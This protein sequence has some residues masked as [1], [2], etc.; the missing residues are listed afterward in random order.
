[1]IT[2]VFKNN[3]QPVGLSFDSSELQTK[4]ANSLREG[5]QFVASGKGESLGHVGES[6]IAM[7]QV[8]AVMVN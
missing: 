1:M 3:H 6:T 5:M 7:S 4:V 2:I 8:A